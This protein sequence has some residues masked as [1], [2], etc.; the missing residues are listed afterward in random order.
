MIITCPSCGQIMEVKEGSNVTPCS[1]CNKKIEGKAS[2]KENKEREVLQYN[3]SVRAIRKVQQAFAGA[4]EILGVKND[5]D[6][7]ALVNEVRYGK[8]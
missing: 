2:L 6:V 3:A 1:Y 4:A 5:D 7:M 8:I